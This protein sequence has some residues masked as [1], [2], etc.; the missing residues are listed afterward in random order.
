MQRNPRA[1]RLDLIRVG[2]RRGGDLGKAWFSVTAR[3]TPSVITAI[4]SINEAEQRSVSDA[5]VAEVSFTAF[6]DRR[7]A[8]NVGSR[9]VVRRVK[10][11][12]PLASDGSPPGVSALM[13]F[14]RSEGLSLT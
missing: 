12:Q 11:L 6:T 7:R 3:L 9:L 10:R 14:P 4:A 1:D 5:E 2:V 8:E 13:K